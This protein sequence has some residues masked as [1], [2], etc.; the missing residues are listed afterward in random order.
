M[1]ENVENVNLEETPIVNEYE[2][3]EFSDDFFENQDMALADSNTE[4]KWINGSN[5]ANVVQN[6]FNNPEMQPVETIE[7][8]ETPIVENAE[9]IEMTQPEEENIELLDQKADTDSIDNGEMAQSND[10]IP[11]FEPDTI[12]EDKFISIENGGKNESTN[13]DAYFDS[14]YE[15]VEGANNLISEI[16]SKKKS[17]QESEDGIEQI[18]EELTKEKE[19]LESEKRKFEES[20]QIQKNRL[21]EEEEQIKQDIE[22]KNRELDLKEQAI[23]IEQE[24]LDSD[25]EQF[26]KYKETEE[27]KIQSETE[28]INN[29]KQQ[30]EKDTRLN[31]QTIENE[32]KELDKDKKHFTK[33]KESEEKR[34]AFEKE[35]LAQSCSRFKQLVSQF[36]SNFSKLPE[37][38]D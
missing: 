34:I 4:E 30:L 2:P 37:D 35:N 9:T 33:T 3:N 16:I 28:K 8:V 31:L 20:V 23:K 10:E 11:T 19:N 26:N 15:N 12:N 5:Q 13:F 24:K 1:N 25:K 36:N 21:Q 14:L 22:V 29:E 32:R 18:K 6:V 7:N 27:S 38:K 17:I